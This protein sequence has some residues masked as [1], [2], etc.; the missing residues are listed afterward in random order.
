MIAPFLDE[1]AT[2]A[3]ERYVAF[4][5]SLRGILS[6]SLTTPVNDVRAFDAIRRGAHEAAERFIQTEVSLVDYAL[7]QA[8]ERAVAA[9]VAEVIDGPRPATYATE[10]YSSE[11]LTWFRQELRAQVERDINSL[12][13][14][15][16]QIA[17][18]AVT[19]ARTTGADPNHVMQSMV[20][21]GRGGVSFM[22]TDRAG[23]RY[24]SQKF[25]RQLVRHTLLTFAVESAATEAA[26]F[27]FHTVYISHPD[28]NHAYDGEAISLV[29]APNMLSLADV[30]DDV[31]HPNSTAFL[32]T[33]EPTR[34]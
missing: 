14:Q 11:L 22:F 2:K 30:R 32:T 20:S 34:R 27:L 31:F 15:R 19:T 8:Q 10:D 17:L 6:V 23:K 1:E 18:A 13:Q 16:R 26:S 24:P 12:V 33:I 3:G 28:K 9:I 7:D 21:Q 5:L 4:L 25:Y 29:E